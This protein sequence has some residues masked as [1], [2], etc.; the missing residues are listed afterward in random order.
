MNP[1]STHSQFNQR[2]PKAGPLSQPSRFMD[3]PSASKQGLPPK[4][5]KSTSASKA[6]SPSV[7][8]R[9]HIASNSRVRSDEKMRTDMFLSYINNALQEKSKVQ[10]LDISRV[11]F[12]DD[13]PQG[14]TAAFNDLV[15]QFSS[16]KSNEE[17]MQHAQLRYWIA[18]LTHVVSRLDQPH[19]VLVES[20]VNMPWTTMDS[21]TVKAYTVFVGVLLSARP[22]YLS[23]VLAKIAQGFTHRKPS[24]YDVSHQSYA[25]VRI[26][27][28]SIGNVATRI[29]VQPVASSR[30]IR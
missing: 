10:T 19:A 15:N 23:L 20:L 28:S 25:E 8:Y 6:S 11:R 18:A 26:R 12:S 29:I 9:R 7:P 30:C 17:P 24:Y 16:K 27:D 1:H 13:T 21:A 5:S 14:N 22:E 2:P 3:I 4:P